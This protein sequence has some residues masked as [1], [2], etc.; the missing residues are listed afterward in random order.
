MRTCVTP[1]R[2]VESDVK[3]K[4]FNFKF[5]LKT[6][7]QVTIMGEICSAIN[8]PEHGI[9]PVSHFTNGDFYVRLANQIAC[10]TGG[11]YN[12]A[13]VTVNVTAEKMIFHI[14]TQKGDDVRIDDFWVNF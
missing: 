5:D 9:A 11:N 13:V 14:F 4:K 2:T 10:L 12:G 7:Q 3:T 1:N 8:N 6:K